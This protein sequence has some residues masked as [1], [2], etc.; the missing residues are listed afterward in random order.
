MALVLTP[1]PSPSSRREQIRQVP[2]E[3]PQVLLLVPGKIHQIPQQERLHHGESLPNP[4]AEGFPGNCV[5]SAAGIWNFEVFWMENLDF[6]HVLWDLGRI[7]CGWGIH[8]QVSDPAVEEETL[9]GWDLHLPLGG[10][11]RTTP[12][13]SLFHPVSPPQIAIY[14]TNFCT[15]ARNAF[16]L[17]MRNIIR[18]GNLGENHP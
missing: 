1:L 6:S 8:I 11:V 12:F 9:P 15:S 16:F 4:G 13:L 10:G 2:P 3:L 5:P 17:L 18:W 14:G 7:L